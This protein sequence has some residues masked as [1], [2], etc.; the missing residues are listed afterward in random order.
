M[1]L[2]T[3]WLVITITFFLLHQLPGDPFETEKAIPPQ[4]KANLMAKYNLDKPL[5]EQYVVYLKIGER[6][7]GYFDE[8]ERK[9]S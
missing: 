5:M 9:N 7:F 1:G 6:R 2:V 8:G 3:L 4:V